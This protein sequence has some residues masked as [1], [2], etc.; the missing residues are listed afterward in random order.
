MWKSRA[1][2]RDDRRI[3]DENSAGCCRQ[4]AG[5]SGSEGQGRV[6]PGRRRQPCGS[7]EDVLPTPAKIHGFGDEAVDRLGAEEP[8][9]GRSF[10]RNGGEVRPLRRRQG[11]PAADARPPQPQLE[12]PAAQCRTCRQPRCLAALRLAANLDNDTLAFVEPPAA[13][14]DLAR[15]QEGRPVTADIDEHRTERRQ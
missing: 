9:P 2:F 5:K 3:V 11:L 8:Q 6:E 4:R 12:E 14:Q 1:K 15:G 7:V 10:S 13:R